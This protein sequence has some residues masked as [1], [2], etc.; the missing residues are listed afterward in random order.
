MVSKKDLNQWATVFAGLANQN[1]LKILRLLAKNQSMSVTEIAK[2]LGISFKNTS[3]NL[4]IL[5][6][7]DLIRFEGK[8]DRVY[9]HLNPKLSEEIK[10]ILKAVIF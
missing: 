5:V 1:R 2:E 10:A 7:L 3:R 9:Y 6:N 8:K 4:R